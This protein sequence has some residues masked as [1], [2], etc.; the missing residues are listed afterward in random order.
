MLSPRVLRPDGEA[1]RAEMPDY[2]ICTLVTDPAQYAELRASFFARGFKPPATEYLFIDNSRGQEACA[3]HG[4]NALLAVARGRHVI[5]CHQDV[6][7]LAE[8]RERLDACLAEL[9]ARDPGWAVAGNAGG[10]RPGALAIRISDPHGSDQRRGALPCRVASLDEN[11]LIVRRDTRVG[12][13][14]DLSGFHFYGAD[15]CL[16]AD[17]MGYSCYVVDFHLRH[18]SPGRKGAEFYACEAAFCTKWARALRPRWVQTTCSLVRVSGIA[19]DRLAGSLARPVLE[20]VL[21]RVS[22]LRP[23]AAAGLQ[24]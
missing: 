18:L 13:S 12:F 14:R 1:S 11:F 20:R 22:R 21:R 5:L 6:R 16:A 23:Q 15:L 17:L 2:S 7:L 24:G 9:D 3:Y 4:G 8:G 19:S 10:I